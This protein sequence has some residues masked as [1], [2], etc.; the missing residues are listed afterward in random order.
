MGECHL[1]KY[2]C[3]LE[4]GT[5]FYIGQMCYKSL[6]R[7][8]QLSTCICFYPNF[9]DELKWKDDLVQHFRSAVRWKTMKYSRL[10]AVI[11][12][13]AMQEIGKETNRRFNGG[14]S[15]PAF[16]QVYYDFSTFRS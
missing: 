5:G 4:A 3:I 6:R 9:S 14:K 7:E 12:S 15:W 1:E 11:I 2:L 10:I 16:S 8:L 13:T